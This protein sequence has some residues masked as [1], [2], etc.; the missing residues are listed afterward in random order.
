MFALALVLLA[1]VAARAALDAVATPAALA[2][3]VAGPA[4]PARIDAANRGIAGTPAL[5]RAAAAALRAGR[6]ELWRE[7][8]RLVVRPTDAWLAGGEGRTGRVHLSEDAGRSW[9][10]VEL[11][12]CGNAGCALRLERG[13]AFALVTGHE[14]PCGGGTQERLVGRLGDA[15]F[16]NAPWPWDTPFD[17]ALPGDGFAAAGCHPGYALG[18]AYHGPE[19]A[20]CLVD[21][22]GRE[23][24]LPVAW[25]G[26]A[27][28]GLRVWP[29]LA[30]YGGALYVF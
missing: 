26:A 18:E 17:F 27:V 14:A 13:G 3:A 5:P 2:L 1:Q 22:A 12:P 19:T 28:A 24:Y 16:A 10:V 20:L 23:A 21:E 6:A 4:A 29:G 8:D 25:D 7:G 30:W 9:R 15:E 11:P